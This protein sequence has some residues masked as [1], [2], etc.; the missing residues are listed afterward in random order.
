MN[1]GT[2]SH[3]LVGV[4]RADI[5]VGAACL[6][7]TACASSRTADGV[8]SAELVAVESSQEEPADGSTTV[9]TITSQSALAVAVEPV[10]VDTDDVTSSA[11]QATGSPGGG[12]V[13]SSEE[14]GEVQDQTTEDQDDTGSGETTTSA[15][16]TTSST[17]STSVVS[18]TSPSEE[19]TTT[20]VADDTTTTTEATSSSN[21]VQ[22]LP[23]SLQREMVDE[24]NQR[25]RD[26]GLE[27]VA[28]N[29]DLADEAEECARL[30]LAR[31]ELEH[32][33]HEVLWMGGVG[34]APEQLL[35]AWFNSPLHKQALTYD[36][37]TEA[38]G[39]LVVDLET[40]R[41]V[42]ALRI[43]Y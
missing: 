26:R 39:A 40:G 17:T 10:I 7:L 11:G 36:S 3:T 21:V 24:L 1:E 33:D 14:D 35:D 23:A 38:G 8:D 25:R 2:T 41:A 9:A 30:S 31:G 13:N 37:S 20:T 43:N 29:Q 5:A 32:C 4:A 6:F 42:A 12:D 18:D 22:L 28:Y 15:V 34:V 19:E 16:A 27:P